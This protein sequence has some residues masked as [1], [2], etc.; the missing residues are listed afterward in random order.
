MAITV[1]EDIES[2]QFVFSKDNPS[3]KRMYS[4]AGTDDELQASA[5]LE[6]TI[7]ALYYGLIFQNYTLDYKGGGLHVSTVTYGKQERMQPADGSSTGGPGA[8][9]SGA[10][11]FDTTGGT[12]KLQYSY[13]TVT[14]VATPG[15]PGVIP[16]NRAIL[17]DP[18]SGKPEGVEVATPSFSFVVQRKLSHPLNTAYVLALYQKTGCVNSD[19][20]VLAVSGIVLS[21]LPGELLYLGST[22][23][24]SG[25]EEW[26]ISL[27]CSA[28]PNS[29]H[30]YNEAP[31][32]ITIN[33]AG[34][35]FIWVESQP[36]VTGSTLRPLVKQAQTEKV[37]PR[38]ALGALFL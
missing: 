8:P 28:S 35:D 11:S 15:G 19:T 38:A 10:F 37:Y 5:A 13:E 14:Q 24:Q 36:T 3:A 34:Q 21:F 12:Q 29:T 4:I 2:R 1:T 20:V 27:K 25:I 23:Q 6:A 22:G 9:K 18:T 31:N 26:D 33:K 16:T 30:T 7:T 32:I 17:I